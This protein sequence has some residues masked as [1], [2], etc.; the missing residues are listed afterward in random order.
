MTKFYIR[1][2][3]NDNIGIGHMM[4]CLSIAKAMR[5]R[6]VELTFFVA[7]KKSAAMVAEAGFGYVCLN[8]D[9]DLLD[10]ES[11]KLLQIMR[12]RCADRLLIDSYYVTETYLQKI[13]EVAHVAYIDDINKFIY[14][15]D[16]L[17]NYNIYAGELDYEKRYREAG[18]S[19]RFALGLS[20]MPLREEY[21]SIKPV[22][23]ER[24]RVL[25]TTGAT[26][27]RNIL[28]H[29]IEKVT[30]LH[31]NRD[32]DFLLI[33]GRY[34][35]NRE[36]LLSRFGNTPGIHLI[37]PQNTLADL[38]SECDMAVT[39]GGTTVYELC[40]GGLPAVMLTLAD[41]QMRA[42]KAFEERGIIPY[43]GDVREDMDG[44]ID[45][46]TKKLQ[47]Y[48]D[49]ELRSEVSARMKEVVDGCGADRLADIL[50][51]EF[52]IDS[53]RHNA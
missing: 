24:L 20:Y 22:P 50:I 7:D 29:L 8:S 49:A 15:C 12:E 21:R 11:D 37:D 25:V 27:D 31:M 10:V 17:I 1:V 51:R 16:L 46:I 23:H 38:I 52:E 30:A 32:M 48:R 41:N 4:R 53:E 33:I 9:Y 40:A 2:D 35:H 13:R 14:P 3:A 34:N 45:R 5:E 44:V 28:G 19:T 18:L 43:A 42:A 36:A 26:D 47:G 39:A 6:G